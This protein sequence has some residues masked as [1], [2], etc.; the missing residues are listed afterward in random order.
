MYYNFV[1]N[2]LVLYEKLKICFQVYHLKLRMDSYKINMQFS[3]KE[4]KVNLNV[5]LTF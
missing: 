2:Y 3:M 1:F 4:I 5:L